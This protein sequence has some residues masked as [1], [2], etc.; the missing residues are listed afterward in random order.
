[1]VNIFTWKMT[2]MPPVT[3]VYMLLKENQWTQRCP[4]GA[5]K[6]ILLPQV[7]LIQHF[8]RLFCN[9]KYCISYAGIL[10]GLK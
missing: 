10:R 9:V 3:L 2:E 5:F 4:T 7:S 1:M 8:Y 6:N